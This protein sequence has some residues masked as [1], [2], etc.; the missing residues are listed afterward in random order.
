MTAFSSE[1][2]AEKIR[3]L[4]V[5]DVPLNNWWNVN[6][7]DNELSYTTQRM[8]AARIRISFQFTIYA[9]A[10]MKPDQIE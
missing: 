8:A 2:R 3:K 5:V 1:V 6:Y 4:R 9:S 7:V 10:P